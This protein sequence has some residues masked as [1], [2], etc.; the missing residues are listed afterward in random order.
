MALT[1]PCRVH[2]DPPVVLTGEG[3]AAREDAMEIR[4]FPFSASVEEQYLKPWFSILN[5]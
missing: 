2:E 5:A 1:R 4:K 3:R